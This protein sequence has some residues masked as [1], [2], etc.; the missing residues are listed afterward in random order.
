MVRLKPCNRTSG[1]GP[2]WRE[3]ISTAPKVP[4]MMPMAPPSYVMKSVGRQFESRF[5]KWGEK[6]APG[7]A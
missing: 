2:G 1:D 7:R 5:V 3:A 4:K 6:V